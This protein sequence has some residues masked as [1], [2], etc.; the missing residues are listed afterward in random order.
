MVHDV[1]GEEP[2][3]SGAFD[4]SLGTEQEPMLGGE[5]MLAMLTQHQLQQLE[6]PNLSHNKRYE[7]GVWLADF[8]DPRPGVGL[9]EDGLPDIDW[10]P[11][12]PGEQQI[13][14][15]DEP[16]TV[17]RVAIARYP[18]TWQQYSTFLN[19]ED[20]HSDARWWPGLR[21]REEYPR[22]DLMRA[23]DPAQEVSW[24]DAV[25]FCRWLSSKLGYTVRLPTEWEWQRAAT[26]GDLERYYPWGREWDMNRANTRESALRGVSAVGLYP[27][28]I[29]PSGAYDMCGTVLE[30]CANTF[31]NPRD[32]E[33][34]PIFTMDYLA[35]YER[36]L[37]AEA[38]AEQTLD[39]WRE[40]GLG[41]EPLV[42]EIDEAANADSIWVEGYVVQ[43][44]QSG[45]EEKRVARGGSWFSYHRYAHT[46]FRT[47]Y[48]PY[49]RFNSV[50]IRLV[51]DN[52]PSNC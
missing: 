30:W 33:L 32:V 28:G 48:D 9:N 29:A 18:V 1:S 25:A 3:I 8:G 36:Q 45:D 20:G 5:R 34:D 7:I 16:R 12:K 17:G 19:A 38:L 31:N 50:G 47:G 35:E 46:S 22:M 52:S 43:D 42:E 2:A 44:H 49:F 21:R 15:E 13:R 6:N 4:Y 39:E 11:V 24:Y 41:T 10:C 23:N 40:V 26:D 51:T 14:S 37:E 27:R